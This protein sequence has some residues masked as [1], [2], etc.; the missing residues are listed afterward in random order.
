MFKQTMNA[1]IIAKYQ[2]K[3][4]A[5]QLEDIWSRARTFVVLRQVQP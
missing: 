1:Q 5:G 3:Y 4:T 2:R